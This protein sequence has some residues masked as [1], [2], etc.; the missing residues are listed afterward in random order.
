MQK[1]YNTLDRDFKIYDI[2]LLKKQCNNYIS[3]DLSSKVIKAIEDKK[4]HFI[5][6]VQEEDKNIISIEEFEKNNTK[7]PVEKKTTKNT[8]EV[9]TSKNNITINK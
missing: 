6:K 3:Y 7:E 2:T 4:L 1:Y 9:F 8:K 5:K